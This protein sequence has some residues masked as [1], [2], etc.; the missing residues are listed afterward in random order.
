M[1][2]KGIGYETV[3]HIV[4]ERKNGPFQD[5]FDFCI[6]VK[7]IKRNALETLVLAGAFDETYSNRASLL[8]SIDQAIDR[9]ELFGDASGQGELFSNAIR[10]RPAYTEIEDFSKM[11]K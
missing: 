1:A 9:A 7:N 6:R 3:H 5:L 8:A 11:Q 2:I 10:M 4:E